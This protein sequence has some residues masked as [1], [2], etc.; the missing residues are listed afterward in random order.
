[1]ASGL[2]AEGA[3]ALA[4]RLA[5]AVAEAAAPHGAP[6]AVAAGIATSP[7]DGAAAGALGELADERLFAARAAGVPVV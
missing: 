5:G 6:L 7:Q 1:V 2:D 4:Q 3:R